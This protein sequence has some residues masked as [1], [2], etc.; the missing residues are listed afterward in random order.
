MSLPSARPRARRRPLV[1]A[2]VSALAL[3]AT[4]VPAGA[5]PAADPTPVPP[6]NPYAGPD[7]TATM[8]GDT[9]SSDT[10]PLAGPGAGNLA[11]KRVALA[12]A[13]P[14]V[15]V[16]SDGYPVVLCTPIFGQVPTVHLLNP[17]D[18]SSLT[19]LQ[20]T[21]GSLLGGV[22]AYLDNEDRLV[23][24][25]GSRSLLRVAHRKDASGAWRL[26]VDRSLSLASAVPADD[27]V[28]GLSPDWRGRVWFATGNGVVGLADD[29]TGQV[30][31]LRL[32]A[33]ERVA[34][35]ISTA[36]EG[37]AVTST[38][39][40]YLLTAGADGTPAIAWRQAYD[41]GQ[42]RKPG[43]LSWGS[44][45]TPTFLGPKTGTDY[46]AIVDNADTTVRLKVYRTDGGAEI[47]SVPVLRASGG[48][49]SENSPVGAG[50]SVFVAGTYGYPYPALPD[51]AGP[52][53]PSSADFAG[54]LTRVDIRPDG[55][56]CATVWDNALRSAAVPKLSTAT[57][58]LH[59]VVR[60]PLIP[61]TRGTGIL[62]PYRYVQIDPETGRVT[63][64]KQVGV[65]SLYDT[66]QMAGTVA[67]DGAYLQGTVTGV[68]RIT[69]G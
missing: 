58:T 66:L 16:G 24:V 18:G 68:L 50:N 32:P 65:G 15:L 57:N 69:A 56:G 54:G 6:H 34:N 39:A 31:T 30:S 1:A 20:L 44:G 41:R 35:S 42:A 26:S 49:G 53:V 61:G 60:D 51:G 3:A 27:A 33:G 4:A 22:Y 55:T 14:T 64:S 40:T 23:V 28:T 11:S 29:R 46:V 59:T 9:G 2:L 38:H 13:C 19:T 62:D 10:T 63:R 37:A 8:H 45:S 36:P 7:G 52:S 5:A 25:D 48:P 47:C 67:P 43:L 17:A 12:S 21:K